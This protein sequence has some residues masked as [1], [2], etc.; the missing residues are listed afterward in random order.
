MAVAQIIIGKEPPNAERRGFLGRG[1]MAA[2]HHKCADKTS[3]KHART[4]PKF[5]SA[6]THS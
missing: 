4:T 6:P 2:E 3:N 5:D 1:R